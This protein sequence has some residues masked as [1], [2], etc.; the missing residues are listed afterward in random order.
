MVGISYPAKGYRQIGGRRRFSKTEVV[1]LISLASF[2]TSLIVFSIVYSVQH[3]GPLRPA[4][5]VSISGS[6][7]FLL[8]ICYVVY[9]RIHQARQFH[10]LENQEDGQPSSLSYTTNTTYSPSTEYISPNMRFAPAKDFRTSR[11][12]PFW[13]SSTTILPTN[14]AADEERLLDHSREQ[15]CTT[16]KGKDEKLNTA[17]RDNSHERT[18]KIKIIITEPEPV[19]SRHGMSLEF[20]PLR[21]HPVNLGRRS[22]MKQSG[23]SQNLAPISTRSAESDKTA[24][25]RNHP[26]DLGP[27]TIGA[28]MATQPRH[29]HH[30]HL[31]KSRRPNL[32]SVSGRQDLRAVFRNGQ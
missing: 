25:N 27:R 22:S 11:N 10:D 14:A 21:S 3:R 19:A 12:R 30:H 15:Q 24:S 18:N 26:V 16:E 23:T 20:D 28:N 31:R 1:L 5:V 9:S 29:N 2:T 4:L 8:A 13:A 17:S 32:S 6:I 7:I